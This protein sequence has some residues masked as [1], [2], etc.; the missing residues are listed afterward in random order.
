MSASGE[1]SN[2]A[3]NLPR[4]NLPHGSPNLSNST[5]NV[6]TPSISDLPEPSS[7]GGTTAEKK[8]GCSHYERRCAYVSPCCNRVYP[9]RICHDDRE[10]HK[11]NR[12]AV[13]EI[14]CLL[15]NARQPVNRCCASCGVEFGRY[16]CS[17]CRLYDD[18]DKKQFHCDQ[19]GICRVDGRENF[20]H[21]PTCDICL[22]ID[23]KNSHKCVEQVTHANCSVCLEDL[24]TS[25]ESLSVLSCGHITHRKC[26]RNLLTSGIY[27]CPLCC[28][29]MVDMKSTWSSLDLEIANTPMPE[30]YKNKRVTILCRDCH[31]ISSVAFHVIGLKCQKCSSYNTCRESSSCTHSTDSDE[32]DRSSGASSSVHD[33]RHLEINGSAGESSSSD[34]DASSDSSSVHEHTL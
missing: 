25:R 16:F 21:C 32:D 10:N 22:C 1:E 18:K 2:S 34:P 8:Y 14:V 27:A 4:H 15:C 17:I 19:C 24:H 33:D 23:L 30:E 29:T 5:H 6:G 20:F 9:C 28:H 7:S 11:I 3:A 26:F 13:N 31:K 12:H